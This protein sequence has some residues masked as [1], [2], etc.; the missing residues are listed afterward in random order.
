MG[1]NQRGAA[2]QHAFARGSSEHKM[3]TNVGKY[4]EK[5][6]S[7]NSWNRQT[8]SYA[9][10]MWNI[11]YALPERLSTD[12]AC[13]YYFI[14]PSSDAAYFYVAKH[15]SSSSS[16]NSNI[17]ENSNVCKAARVCGK[18]NAPS[19]RRRQRNR[20]NMQR[21]AWMMAGS[22][23]QHTIVAR[24]RRMHAFPTHSI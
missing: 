13:E 2:G 12:M 1:Y 20:Q 15:S 5:N 7:H 4:T 21:S 16:N 19:S 9:R 23:Q 11:L 3:Y 10:K 14:K 8:H 18:Y 6:N 17:T 22:K 24:I